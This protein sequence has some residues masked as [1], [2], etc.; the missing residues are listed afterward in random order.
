MGQKAYKHQQ[1]SIQFHDIRLNGGLNY[2]EAPGNI[3]DN[4]LTHALNYIYDPQTGTPEIRPATL[5]QTAAVCD[6][7]NGILNIY[8]YE[9]SSTTAYLVGVCNGNLYY[10]SGTGLTAWTKIGALND[11]TTVPMFATFHGKLLVADGGTNIKTWDGTTYSALAD[12]LGATA[13]TVIKGRVVVNSTSSG[14]ADLVTMSGAEDE[15]MWNTAD[16]TN[17]AIALRAGYGD[18]MVVTGFAVF[19]DDLFVFKKGTSEKSVYKIN[20]GDATA[21]NWYCAMLTQNNG[22]QSGRA[23]VSA[24]ND[25]FFMDTY[26]FKSLRGVTEYGD[27]QVEQIGAKINNAFTAGSTCK[28]LAYIPYYNAIWFIVGDITYT[29]TQLINAGQKS[30]VFTEL[31]FKQGTINAVCQAGSTIYLAGNN[32]YLYTLDLTGTYATDETAPDTTSAYTSNLVTKQFSYFGGF[33]LRKT[34]LYLDPI[35]SG[36]AYLYAVTDLS[37]NIL[38]KTVTLQSSGQLLYDATGY[39]CDATEY[40]HDMGLAAWYEYTRNRV[41][42]GTLQFKITATSGRVGIEGLKAE[43]ALVE[44]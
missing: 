16:P 31:S 44:G 6:S 20:T 24:F 39:L 27:L 18:N 41:R 1:G 9:K 32:G 38:L 10:L 15:T 22:A 25:V 36:T 42:G 11:K 37:E 17:P 13:I 30:Y 8:Y 33:I 34:S 28:M 23:I 29:C 35:V 40:L 4:E 26:A 21:A 43:I 3:Q 7:T 12:G 2:S 19:G 14:S 5:C